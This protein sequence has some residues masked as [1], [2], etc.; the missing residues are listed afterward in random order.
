MLHLTCAKHDYHVL[1][2]FKLGGGA[3][4]SH[5]L[6]KNTGSML[7]FSCITTWMR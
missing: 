4:I 1:I 7:D 2:I 3:Q 5:N 6:H